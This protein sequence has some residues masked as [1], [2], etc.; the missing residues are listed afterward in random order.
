MLFMDCSKVLGFGFSRHGYQTQTCYRETSAGEGSMLALNHSSRTLS[1][2]AILR[3]TATR[4]VDVPADGRKKARTSP[5][6]SLFLLGILPSPF[7][8]LFL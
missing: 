4:S 5:R 2:N 7:P 6:S 3:V 1:T 8:K